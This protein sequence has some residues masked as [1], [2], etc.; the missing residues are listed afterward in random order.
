MSVGASRSKRGL[1]PLADPSC[2]AKVAV[3]TGLHAFGCIGGLRLKPV[4]LLITCGSPLQ[5]TAVNETPVAKHL[6]DRQGGVLPCI[7][8]ARLNQVSHCSW[9]LGFSVDFGGKGA[10]WALLVTT[11]LPILHDG[12]SDLVYLLAKRKPGHLVNPGSSHTTLL[13]PSKSLLP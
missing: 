12:C 4:R 7:L 5:L 2:V 11:I 8:Q 9:C 13:K 1:L 10:H 6:P 3:E